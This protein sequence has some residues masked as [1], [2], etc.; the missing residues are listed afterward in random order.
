MGQ[1]KSDEVLDALQAAAEG[2]VENITLLKLALERVVWICAQRRAGL[3]YSEMA[4]HSDLPHFVE[5]YRTSLHLLERDGHR[6]RVAG[7]RTLHAEGLS[8]DRIAEL[9]GVSRQRVS[10]LLRSPPQDSASL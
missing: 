5:F 8:I 10:V 6:L 9:F 1:D 4:D 7:V 2:L 3:T